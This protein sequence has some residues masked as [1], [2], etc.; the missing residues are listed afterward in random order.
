M[1]KDSKGNTITL[2]GGR[3]AAKVNPLGLTK[4]YRAVCITENQVLSKSWRK[5]KGEAEQDGA[6]HIDKGH[7]VDYEVRITG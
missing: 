6:A 4:Q 1:V 7:Y 2:V 3:N 5:T